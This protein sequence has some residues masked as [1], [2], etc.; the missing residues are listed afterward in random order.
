MVVLESYFMKPYF[1]L[2]L[3]LLPLV[4]AEEYTYENAEALKDRIEWRDYGSKAF[5]EAIEQN[6]PV[7]LSKRQ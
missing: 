7:F 4:A 1:L 5:D 6:K 2:L 3:L